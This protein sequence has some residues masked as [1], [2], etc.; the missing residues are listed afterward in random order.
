MAH[1]VELWSAYFAVVKIRAF[2]EIPGGNGFCSQTSKNVDNSGGADA[3]DAVDATGG[4]S[5][6]GILSATNL[7]VAATSLVL[8]AEG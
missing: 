6:L 1:S 8:S 7:V 5:P 2:P 3:A 4:Q